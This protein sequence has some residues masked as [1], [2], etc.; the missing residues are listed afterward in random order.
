MA[1]AASRN[2]LQRYS[3]EILKPT[4]TQTLSLRFNSTSTHSTHQDHT[5]TDPNSF[6]GSWTAPADP[7]VAQAKL[8]GLRRDYAKKVKELR[9]Q[10]IHEVE[11]QREDKRRKDEAKREAA[12]RA[13]AE[14]KASKAAAAQARAAER[15]VFEEEFRQTLLKERTEKLEN[16]RMKENMMDEKRKEKNE[17]LRRQSSIWIDE[18]DLEK[19]ILEAIVDT[20]HL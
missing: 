9:L 10:Y 6:I 20:T 11:L 19:K 15:K 3:A 16:W 7:K 1:V 5:Y 13:Q 4:L 14:I 18:R 8:T 2:T 17:L 12:R